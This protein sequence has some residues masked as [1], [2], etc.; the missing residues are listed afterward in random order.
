MRRLA[1]VLVVI[2]LLVPLPAAHAQRVEPA[3]RDSARAACI[4]RLPIAAMVRVRTREPGFVEHLGM[5]IAART[6]GLV[7]LREGGDTVCVPAVQVHTLHRSAGF[8]TPSEA[9][10]RGAG[11]GPLIGAG[12]GF[13]VTT[14]VAIVERR[15]GC[16]DC[17]FSRT[18][19]S[20][21]LST[22][23]TIATTVIGGLVGLD[24]REQWVRE[25]PPRR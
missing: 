8:R 18:W 17:L 19:V 7:L 21:V 3:G 14:V 23:F 16:S 25:W 10:A 24:V 15:N 12:V 13:I 11:R 9:M 4:A 2:T 5:V 6:D 1:T 20:A 22:G